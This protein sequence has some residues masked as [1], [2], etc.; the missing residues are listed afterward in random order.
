MWKTAQVVR[1][2][3]TGVI[4]L[5]LSGPAQQLQIHLIDHPQ[6]RRTDGMTE[7]LESPVHLGRHFTISVID[8]VQDI[9]PGLAPFRDMQVFVGHEFRDGKT[10]MK[11]HHAELLPGIG[12]SCFP[13]GFGAAFTGCDE[14]LTVPLVKASLVATAHGKL[15]GLDRNQLFFLQFPGD[16]WRRHNGAGRAITDTAAVEQSQWMRDNGRRQDLIHRH[17]FA[18][19]GLGIQR[20]IGVTL[21]RYVGNGALQVLFGNPVF[22]RIGRGKLSEKSRRRGIRHPL[23]EQ[24]SEIG[25]GVGKASVAGIFQL[26]HPQGQTDIVGPG[27]HG[28]N[29]P[30]EGLR[31]RR[32]E[33]LHA[34]H[35]DMGQSQGHPHRRGAL[36]HI[37]LVHAGAQPGRLNVLFF[38]AR[39]GKA[40]GEGLD[41]QFLAPHIPAFTETGAAHPDDRNFILDS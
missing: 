24:R 10:V 41:H 17:H 5:S 36:S 9:L 2:T 30:P 34:A 22:G 37:D 15:Q 31:T 12:D 11:F 32:A 39:I 7:T 3:V 40:F 14:M 20:S 28:I 16:L 23:P 27:R 21:D 18:K 4:E 35:G 6:S 33:I 25:P 26:L 1:Q 8:A 13:V 29:R 38:N 19:M